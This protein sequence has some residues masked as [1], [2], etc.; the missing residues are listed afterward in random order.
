M[1]LNFIDQIRTTFDTLPNY[2]KQ[3]NNLKY[4]ITDTT[5]SAFSVFSRKARL[6]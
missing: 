6:F 2:R 5:L 3:G 4:A 1:D